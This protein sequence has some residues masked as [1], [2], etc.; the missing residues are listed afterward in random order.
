MALVV[1]GHPI[2]TYTRA[3]RLALEEKGVAY[4]L[5]T[6]TPAEMKSPEHLARHPFGKMPFL[7]HDGFWLY[8]ARAILE[9]ADAAF[10]GPSLRAVGAKRAA[11]ME[12]IVHIT[13]N[14]VAPAWGGG[15]IRPRLI[16]ALLRG[17]APDEGEIARD[18]PQSIR[19]AEVLEG[20]LGETL[21][22]ADDHVTFADLMLAP[23]YYS[24]S[25]TPEA[26]AVLAPFPRLSAW[27]ARMA[28]RP[29]ME[30]TRPDFA[31]FAA[32]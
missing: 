5:A 25:Q 19:C 16:G 23:M 20:L 24:V 13:N 21:F 22:A 3:A 2:S 30:A 15:I 12:Q 9:Y 28:D 32:R 18:L 26:A 4:A 17:I 29:S 10:D 27:W 6:I 7:E 8:E 1:H 14:Y 31:A 11:R